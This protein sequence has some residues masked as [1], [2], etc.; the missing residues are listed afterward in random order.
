VACLALAAGVAGSKPL[1]R[2]G[3]IVMSVVIGLVLIRQLAAV[4]EA[5]SLAVRL[6]NALHGWKD[7][8]TERE[9]L[10]DQAPVGICRL[11]PGGRVL[12]VNLTLQSMIGYSKDEVIGRWFGDFLHPEERE[13]SVASYVELAEGR[14]DRFAAEGRLLHKDGSVLWCSEVAIP[15]RE[16]DGRL[17]GFIAIVEDVSERRREAERA[18]RI[19]RQLL[20]QSVP[21]ID[22]YELAGACQP[23]TDVAGDFYDWVARDDHIDLTLADV[24]GKGVAA[25]LVMA[26]L[27]TALRSATP[28][29]G[30][31][32][33]L[34]LAADS[35]AL[36]MEDDGLFVTL[37]QGRLDPASGVLRYVDAGHGYCAV[38][39]P[40]GELVPLLGR[41]LPLGV[42]QDEVFQEGE[43]R[44]DP[45]DA[46][47]V[48]TDGLV[49]TPERIAELAEFTRDLGESEPADE[50]VRR[51]MNRVPS[52]A[53]DDV[54]VVVLRRLPGPSSA[55]RPRA[56][57]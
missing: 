27:R 20:P 50:T 10:I 44:L 32:A 40:D 3:V 57:A 47:I 11:D 6:D 5:R 43:V 24:M 34:R 42:R 19:Q 16:E 15:L 21:H 56:A 30:P 41:S 33:R 45:G 26:A 37:F 7:A 28:G 31:A 17:E 51:L 12:D 38:R 54:T 39:R 18:A 22:G 46:L 1:D 29:L 2:F 14:A 35:M 25:A 4:A 52:P 53:A 48:Y 36:G 13:R 8:A 9:I 23:A 55:R 49:E